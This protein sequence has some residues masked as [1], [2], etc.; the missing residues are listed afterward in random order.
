MVVEEGEVKMS[1]V[2]ST[3][4]DVPTGLDR[5]RRAAPMHEW[6]R[7]A[8]AGMA[9]WLAVTDPDD[10]TRV[11]TQVDISGTKNW[12][13]PATRAWQ[14][15][16]AG[17]AE[18]NLENAA[19]VP[20]RRKR[21][22]ITREHLEHVAQVYRAADALG[23]PPT[24]AVQTE[25][26]TTHSTAAKWVSAAR[27]EGILGAALNSRGGEVPPDVA[28]RGGAPGV[29]RSFTDEEMEQQPKPQESQ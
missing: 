25:F 22:R 29:D 27:K 17:T 19:E 9:H 11:I 14:Q 15:Q 23:L 4:S 1:A 12:W 13:G 6:K 26:H 3:L 5:V 2:M 8:I 28:A 20:V 16:L 7:L 18:S 21:N 10:L 24:Q